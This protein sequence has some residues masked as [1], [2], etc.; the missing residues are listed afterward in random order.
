MFKN[1]TVIGSGLMGS[2]IAAHFANAGCKVNLLDII[3][4][5]NENKNHLAD[6]ALKK[7][8]KIKPSPLTLSSNIKLIKTGNLDENLNVINNSEWVIEVIIENLSIKKD[9]FKK[10]DKIMHDDL[11]ISS[12]TSTIPIKLLSEGLS[13]KFKKNFLITHFFNPPRYLKLLEIVKTEETKK[14]IINKCNSNSVILTWVKLL[15]KQMIPQGL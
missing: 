7:L 14:E 2:A 10:I 6:I 9:L 15:L 3:D 13:K 12:N 8:V 4:N 5:R 1:I 11:I